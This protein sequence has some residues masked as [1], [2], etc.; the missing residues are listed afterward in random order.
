MG[1]ILETLDDILSTNKGYTTSYHRKD[2]DEVANVYEAVDN[3]DETQLAML[4]KKINMRKERL[5]F[6]KEQKTDPRNFPT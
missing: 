1:N 6:L 2:S 5:Q 4:E 3:M